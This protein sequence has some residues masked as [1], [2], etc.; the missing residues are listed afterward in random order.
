MATYRCSG[1]K[2]AGLYGVRLIDLVMS[3]VP[4]MRDTLEIG[5]RGLICVAGNT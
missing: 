1:V 2:H 4:A 5:Q 3:S